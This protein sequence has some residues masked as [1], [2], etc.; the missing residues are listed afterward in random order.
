MSDKL[1]MHV[2]AI[3]NGFILTDC[4]KYEDPSERQK[5]PEKKED[6]KKYIAKDSEGLKI[7]ISDLITKR[8][9]TDSKKKETFPPFSGIKRATIEKEHPFEDW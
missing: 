7:L 1:Y 8:F 2:E 6:Y 4:T 5:S 9:L 3:A